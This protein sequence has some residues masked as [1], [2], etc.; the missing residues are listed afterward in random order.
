MIFHNYLT[1]AKHGYNLFLADVPL[2]H[3][4]D[5][6]AAKYNPLPLQCLYPFIADTLRWNRHLIMAH[7]AGRLID[8]ECLAI[9]FRYPGVSGCLVPQLAIAR[10]CPPGRPDEYTMAPGK[11]P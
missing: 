8:A 2:E 5:R 3:S 10:C 6:V 7:G 1:R 9:G 11:H 4:P